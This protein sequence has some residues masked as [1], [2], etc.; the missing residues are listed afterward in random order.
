MTKELQYKRLYEKAATIV[1]IQNGQIHK[2]H[3]EKMKLI[4][5]V[6]SHIEINILLRNCYNCSNSVGCP[7]DDCRNAKD[8]FPY[9]KMGV[10][11]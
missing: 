6:N 4:D 3:S 9:W 2:L 5:T 11:K 8:C 10:I 1:E 7:F